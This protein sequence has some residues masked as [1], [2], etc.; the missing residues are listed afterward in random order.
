[1]KFHSPKFWLALAA[2]MML[3]SCATIAPPQ[4]PSLELPRPPVDLRASRKGDRVILIWTIPTLTTDRQTIRALGPT[5]ICRTLVSALTQCGTPVG[6]A[7]AASNPPAA[8]ASMPNPT[9]A[10]STKQKP[11]ITYTDT[12]PKELLSDDNSA[13][14]TYAVEVFN[15]EGRAAG[16]SNQVHI[17][18]VR[19]PPAPQTFQ[20]N[21]TSQG[22]IL[23]WMGEL[24]PPYP[25]I[26]YAYRVYRRAQGE[27]PWTLVG[28]VPPGNDP[29]CSLTDSDIE[30]EKTYEYRAE[31][32]TFIDRS[33]EAAPQGKPQKELQIEGDDT[34]EITI[35]AHDTFPPA[36]PSGLQAVFSGPGQ[37]PF[38]DLVWAP[39]ADVDLAGYN[40]YR[41]EEGASPTRVNTET[42]RAPAYRDASVPPG[43]Y[44]YSVTSVDLRG[45]ESAPSEEASETVPK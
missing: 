25:P 28:S 17:P 26:H 36:V 2:P 41:H 20:A 5:R 30:W 19:T 23:S 4:P 9:P 13:S 42:V 33:S 31:A 6:E 38:V 12:L 1:M 34:P 39:V 8:N 15:R 35:L 32:V 45:N 24:V 18:L 10:K 11:A 44:F 14:A 16:L 37:K 40:I 27:R 7:A 29:A 43:K 22:I 21:V 3:S